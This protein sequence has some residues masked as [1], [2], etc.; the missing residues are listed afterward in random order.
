M[1]S[2][3]ALSGGADGS[4]LTPAT[5]GNF[6]VALGASAATDNYGIR[7]LEGVP[8]FNLLCVPGETDVATIRDLQAYCAEKRAFLIVDAPA[9]AT[10]ESL[11]SSGPTGIVIGMPGVAA[12][13]AG[14]SVEA[15]SAYYFPWVRALDPLLNS[16][17]LFPPCGFV[18][19]VYA[20]TDATVGVWK[21]PA[22]TGRGPLGASGLQ[23]ALSDAE[24]APL[25]AQAI[26]CLR[27]FEVYG[28]SSG[29]LAR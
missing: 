28:W 22:G 15:N 27:Q 1:N 14:P 24:S 13:V 7:L 20:A 23:F 4:V 16:V 26:N 3:V 29:V 12:S 8:I 18:A 6:E 5:D 19:G 21:A 17:A 9:T 25:D 2:T 11:S 10:P